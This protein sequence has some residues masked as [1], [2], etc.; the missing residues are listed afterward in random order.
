ME[1]NNNKKPSDNTEFG[2]QS[3][4]PSKDKKNK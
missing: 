4:N 1:N 3:N 2:D